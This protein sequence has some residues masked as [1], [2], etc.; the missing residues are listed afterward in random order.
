MRS[1][2]R[3]L[4]VVVV[5]VVA[6]VCLLFVLENPQKVALSFLG[7]TSPE[8]PLSVVVLLALLA[9]LAVGPLIGWF[10]AMRGRRRLRRAAIRQKV[11][12]VPASQA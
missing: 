6:A 3:L 5:L 7:F 12:S 4:Q 9:G 11:N 10:I 8:W 2:T 1:F